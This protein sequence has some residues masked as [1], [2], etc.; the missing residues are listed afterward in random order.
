MRRALYGWAA[1]AAVVITADVLLVTKKHPT[2]SAAF[3]QHRLVAV[4][5]WLVLTSH[6]V[7]GRP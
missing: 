3:R 5:A 7:F 4:P 1:V 2:L 6:L